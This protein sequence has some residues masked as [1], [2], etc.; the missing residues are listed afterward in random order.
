MW[1]LL[2]LYYILY[3]Y[4]I[5]SSEP[6]LPVPSCYSTGI[7]CWGSRTGIVYRY[8]RTSC[9]QVNRTKQPVGVVNKQKQTVGWCEQTVGLCLA[10]PGTSISSSYC[11]LLIVLYQLCQIVL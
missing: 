5:T 2:Y 8:R 7:P 4:G 6:K 3:L 10:V 11:I 1:E 9:M